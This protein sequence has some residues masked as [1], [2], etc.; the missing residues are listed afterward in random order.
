MSKDNQINISTKIMSEIKNGQIKIKPKWRFVLG[1]LG[2]VIGL[3]SLFVLIVFLISLM[4][5]ALRTHGPINAWRLNKIL[6]DFPWWAIF[7]A[8]GGIWLGS[9]SLKNYDFSYKKNFVLIILGIIL[10]VLLAGW[11]INYLAID[12][13]WMQHG[14]VKQLYQKYDG[15]KQLRGPRWRFIQDNE[16]I[17]RNFPNR[18][19]QF[20]DR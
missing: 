6:S 7:I 12:N 17:N 3:A 8:I 1:S 13:V 9:I 18:R 4:V 14:P 16:S 11:S 20:K 5:Y 2:M 15:G 19:G 10:A